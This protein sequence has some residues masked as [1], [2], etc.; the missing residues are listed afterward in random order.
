MPAERSYRLL[1]ENLKKNGSLRFGGVVGSFGAYLAARFLEAFAP[2]QVLL[3]S[4]DPERALVFQDN[5]K[6]F[7]AQLGLDCR[8][9]FFPG[10]GAIEG[11]VSRLVRLEEGERLRI[12]GGLAFPSSPGSSREIISAS[13][14]A[15]FTPLP[16][17]L[18]MKKRALWLRKGESRN[19]EELLNELVALGYKRLARAEE[20]GEF[21]A[22]GGIVDFF[23]PNY[24]NPVRL[25]Y[26]ADRI[27]SLR[28]YE[29]VAQRSIG[30]IG[31]VVIVPVDLATD[32]SSP[33]YLSDYLA[34]GA[35]VI[36]DRAEAVERQ[37]ERQ[38]QSANQIS[39]EHFRFDLAELP[40]KD[41]G[42]DRIDPEVEVNEEL[43]KLRALPERQVASSF[44]LLAEE[45]RALK[46]KGMRVSLV[47]PE[48]A[49]AE[50]LKNLLEPYQV[51]FPR[52]DGQE[53]RNI[54]AVK[55]LIGDLHQGFRDYADQVAFVTEEDIF[56][57][58]IRRKSAYRAL[59]GEKIGDFFELKEGDYL[60]HLDYGIGIF[61]GLKKIQ[62]EESA[63]DFL[64]LQYLG[65]DLLYLPVDR[66]NLLRRYWSQEGSIPV[67]DRLGGRDWDKRKRKVSE[68]V[69]E[70]AGELIKIYASRQVKEGVA[71]SPPDQFLRE[72]EL[73]FP[74]TE[75]EDQSKAIAEV[76]EDLQKPKPMDRL[77]CGDVG[78]GKTEVALRAAFK[79][80]TEGK[81]VALLC[82]TTVLVE[83]HYKTLK[84][85]MANYPVRVGAL[86]RFRSRLEQQTILRDLREGRVDILIGTHRLLSK[87]VEFKDLGLLIID[88]E[89]RFGVRQ[90]EKIK[91]YRALVDVLTLTATPIPRTLQ[92]ALSGIRDLSLISSPPPERHAVHNYIIYFN[93]EEIKTAIQEELSRGGQ[94]FFVHNRV[95]SIGGIRQFLEKILPGVPIGVAHGQM[96]PKELEEV[97]VKFL[98]REVNI[99]LCTAI[100]GSGLDIPSANTIL[101]NRA[102]RFGLAD[103]YQLRGRVGRG[104]DIAYCYFIIPKESP[105]S[106]GAV[107]RLRAI[108]TLADLGSGY[109]LAINDLE[110]RGAGEIF[111]PH[112]SGHIEAVG[113]DLYLEML[114]GEV[115]RLKT[116]EKSAPLEPEIRISPPAFIPENYIEFPEERLEFY[117]RFSLARDDDELMG[118]ELEL[119]DRFGDLPDEAD[120]LVRTLEL[121]L[122]LR[123]LRVKRMEEDTGNLLLWFDDSTPVS[124]EILLELVQSSGK[125]VR[126]TPEGKLIFPL[127]SEKAPGRLGEIRGILDGIIAKVNK[128][129][130]VD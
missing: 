18:E 85:R 28:F 86:S 55:I 122:R 103:L 108:K 10:S 118:L 32:Q 129:T 74:Y 113:Y 17:I 98:N 46:L 61:R 90:K 106:A 79:V 57:P 38:S 25:E 107:E 52:K 123:T 26:D 63:R 3:I 51:R 70:L 93:P 11:M 92:L 47:A 59:P 95:R 56:G 111:G 91:S 130:I 125:R 54:F 101:I 89:H 96:N 42:T 119:L 126:L 58:K 114:E 15:A 43:W 73:S 104:K 7:S 20:V 53:R 121:K 77:V 60:V 69:R 128:L 117:R 76:L 124:P 64:L 34:P 6:F 75:T 66:I 84:S 67:L 13:V 29:P 39:K 24:P 33:V 22:R 78:F 94:V 83:Q 100:I 27:D 9:D 80:A 88:E 102:E 110:I 45:I 5:L 37:G 87:D 62:V 36:V 12:L 1:A 35:L 14:S 21:S 81:Q 30:E 16:A 4:P 99:L 50:R 116:G 112:Q 127:R 65:G 105:F 68:S 40:L 8:F 109:R 49:Q 48:E 120:N 115:N 97:M 41:S 2:R 31:E 72:F 23:C 19:R 44:A 71:F 82:P